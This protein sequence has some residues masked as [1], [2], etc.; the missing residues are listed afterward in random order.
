[1]QVKFLMSSIALLFS[2]GCASAP[3]P[4]LT[5][6]YLPTDTIRPTA[7]PTS[8]F[9]P[10]PIRTNTPTP[11][12]SL[13]EGVDGNCIELRNDKN[14]CTHIGLEKL[15]AGQI[16]IVISNYA[17]SAVL[18][19][20][21]KL[22][23]GKTWQNMSNYMRPLPFMGSQPDWSRDVMKVSVPPGNNTTR[24]EELNKGIYVS[25]CGQSGRPGVWLGG[26]LIVED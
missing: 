18:I 8:T 22:D 10:T 25:I 3:E 21:E 20:L 17:S 9:T 12:P 6:T 16:A 11:L 15:P 13:C 19:D 5:P 24:H 2:V 26:Q 14:G 7:T 23:E 4:T 1:M